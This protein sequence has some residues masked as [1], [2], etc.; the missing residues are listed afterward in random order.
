MEGVLAPVKFLLMYGLLLLAYGAL[1]LVALDGPHLETLARQSLASTGVKLAMAFIAGEHLWA[2]WRDYLRG[3]AWQRRDPT[4]HFWKPFGLAFRAYA[5]FLLGFLI[6][7]W[8]KSPLPVLTV[9]ILLK[10]LGEMLDAL[11]DAQAQ[12]WRRV[13]EDG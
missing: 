10:A 4:F 8:L 6:L 13:D 5:A 2:Y 9:L 12:A 7:G 1:L 3:P 11:V